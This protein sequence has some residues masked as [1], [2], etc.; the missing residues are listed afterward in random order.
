MRPAEPMR[1]AQVNSQ[2]G[3]LPGTLLSGKHGMT[4][5]V[6][7]DS[8]QG[9]G[10]GA[11]LMKQVQRPGNTA[12]GNA[13]SD[14]QINS[15]KNAVPPDFSVESDTSQ[16][17]KPAVAAPVSTA[18]QRGA[19]Q[20]AI[21]LRSP[22]IDGKAQATS[23][24][25]PALLVSEITEDKDGA[26]NIKTTGTEKPARHAVETAPASLQPLLNTTTVGAGVAI[27]AGIPAQG[28]PV[29]PGSFDRHSGELSAIPGEG[30]PKGGLSAPPQSTSP[31]P[32]NSTTVGQNSKLAPAGL[33]EHRAVPIDLPATSELAT[34]GGTQAG[35]FMAAEVHVLGKAD[36]ESAIS[37]NGNAASE[38]RPNDIAHSRPANP[39]AI[40]ASGPTAAPSLSPATT[41][42]GAGEQSPGFP[43][44]GPF[45]IQTDTEIDQTNPKLD[46]VA[47]QLSSSAAAPVVA[48]SASESAPV[49]VAKKAA[50]GAS[51]TGAGIPAA[52][53]SLPS[54]LPSPIQSLVHSPVA[55]FGLPVSASPA[56]KPQEAASARDSLADPFRHLDFGGAPAKL[57]VSTPRQM[58]VGINDGAHGWVEIKAQ[59]ISGQVSASLLTASSEAHSALHDQLPG[60]SQYLAERQI[61][62]QGL[63]VG[64]SHAFASSGGGGAFGQAPEHGSG[65]NQPNYPPGFAAQASTPA[66]LSEKRAQR[67]A[68]ILV[69]PPGTATRINIRV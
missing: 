23:P 48:K 10:F 6:G 67:T 64:Q 66:G 20:S 40:A 2:S 8:D 4:G 32:A 7:G 28:E 57:L 41:A 47:R 17:G 38:L 62:V 24:A 31:S 15:G 18:S 60:I 68:E 36:G 1:S 51:L 22:V 25:F 63:T 21:M 59:N 3:G 34:S 30:G 5:A 44:A 58:E 19:A 49:S 69:N 12:V 54:P 35:A 65:Q 55:H 11:L 45:A 29:A 61:G 16:D 33:R 27:V 43:Q 39:D 26:K 52:V 50:D 14:I 42:P 56:D 53:S 37:L 46:A 13:G 9:A